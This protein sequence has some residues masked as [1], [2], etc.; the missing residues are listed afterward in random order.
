MKTSVSRTA[1]LFGKSLVLGGLIAAW[2]LSLPAS[3]QDDGDADLP[4]GT[5]GEISRQAEEPAGAKVT[6]RQISVGY[7]ELP[8]DLQDRRLQHIRNYYSRFGV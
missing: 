1:V 8:R 6:G 2:A 4:E 5:F 7:A 3:A